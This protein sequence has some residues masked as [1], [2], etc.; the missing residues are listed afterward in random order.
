LTGAT[1]VLVDVND[2]D[3]NISVKSIENSL[4]SKTKAVI[5]VH[6][7]GRA[8]NMKKIMEIARKNNLRVIEDCAH[9]IGAKYDGKHV[10][11]FGDAGCFSFYPT[12]NITT[13]EG[14]MVIT[15]SKTIADH[16]RTARNHGI[17]KS[18]TQRY[19]HGRPWDYD[20]T[21]PGYNYRLDEIRAALGISQLKRINILN[22][23][24]S[25]ACEYYNSKLKTVKGIKI[26][27]SDKADAYHLYVIRIKN[28]YGV[29][30]D[31]LFE[32]LL[33]NGIRTSVHYKPLHEFTVFK[34]RAKIYDKLDN[35]KQAYKEIISLPLYTRI[36]RDIQ[37]KVIAAIAKQ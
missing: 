25:K 3:L 21:E 19:S 37:D 22:Q 34:K 16:I 1:P 8:C 10:G 15:K 32:K 31:Q 28:E 20:V 27:I 29:K 35:S 4:T 5:P 18:L 14:G 13:I 6:F 30:R 2:D 26:P 17:T 24:R 23:M 36:S 9:A 33:K 7:A 12:K 11:T